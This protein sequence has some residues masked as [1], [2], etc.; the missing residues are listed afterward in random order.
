MDG[1]ERKREGGREGVREGGREGWERGKEGE[2]EGGREGERVEGLEGGRDEWM[3]GREG[4]RE[5]YLTNTLLM[6]YT[7]KYSCGVAG[8]HRN[9]IMNASHSVALPSC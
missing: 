9:A 3:Y 1:W 4:G 7:Y 2:R 6:H 8:I 5:L